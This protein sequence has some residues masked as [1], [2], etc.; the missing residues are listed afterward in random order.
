[1]ANS[2]N[3]SAAK[4]RVE[5]AIWVA[6][7]GT[8]LPNDANTKLNVAFK[9]LGFV[10]EDGMINAD[11]LDSEDI[12]EWGGQTVLKI[13]TEKTDDFTFKLIESLNVEVLKF[14][15]GDKNVTGTVET[16]IKVKSTA[17]FREPRAVVV[18]MIMNGGYLKRLVIPK[19]QVSNLSDIEYVNNDSIGYEVTVSALSYT[20]GKEQYNHIEYISKP[21]EV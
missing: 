7:T 21:S 13:S 15:Y 9:E 11:N 1:M 14:V 10:S 8:E 3:V 20:E 12:K 16:G 6:P 4:P 18:D 2:S 17:D 5:G 19:G